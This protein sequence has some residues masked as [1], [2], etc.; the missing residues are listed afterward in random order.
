MK[1]MPIPQQPLTKLCLDVIMSTP[2]PKALC[3]CHNDLVAENIVSTPA[4]FFIDW[5]YACDNN[6]MFDLA[7]IIE[8]HELSQCK[9]GDLTGCLLR[10]RRRRV[11]RTAQSTAAAVPRAVLAVAR[12]TAGQFCT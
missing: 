5:E 7:T 3:C 4:L 1:E 11:A 8:H 2:L 10:R 12:V 9:G 6:P